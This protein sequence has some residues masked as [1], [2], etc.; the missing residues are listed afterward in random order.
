MLDGG[1]IG[2]WYIGMG[3]SPWIILVNY[4]YGHHAVYVGKH[5]ITLFQKVCRLHAATP[6]G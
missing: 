3:I 1:I 6:L 4:Y 5:R 2:F